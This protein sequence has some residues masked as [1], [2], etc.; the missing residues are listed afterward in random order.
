M[1][2]LRWTQIVILMICSSL[3][4]AS[5]NQWHMGIGV[6]LMKLDEMYAAN[7][8]S[9]NVNEGTGNYLGANLF[10]NYDKHP[11]LSYLL[12]IG[13]LSAEFGVTPTG[14]VE[15]TYDFL[16][17]GIIYDLFHTNN[18]WFI[19]AGA[20]FFVLGG[21]STD[22]SFGLV[23]ASQDIGNPV[24]YSLG[25][26]KSH[27]QWL[28]RATMELG[29]VNQWLTEGYGGSRDHHPWN[30]LSLSVSYWWL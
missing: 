23:E 5:D 15:T 8:N 11:S 21:T 13:Q 28:Y 17:L 10:V 19:D 27:G 6:D 7:I 9:V 30:A 4:Y 3:S 12:G 22:T 14:N 25:F 20:T 26:G 29:S 24:S 18:G 2:L 1:T 16:K